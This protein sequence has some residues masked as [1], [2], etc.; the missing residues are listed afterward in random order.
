MSQS[1]ESEQSSDETS[2]SNDESN[3]VIRYNAQGIKLC[4]AITKVGIYCK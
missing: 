3:E 1:E 2:H 4:E